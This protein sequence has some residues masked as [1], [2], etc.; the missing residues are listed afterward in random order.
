MLEGAFKHA[1]NKGNKG[2]IHAGGVQWMTAGRGVVHSET[3]ATE[4]VNRGLQLVRVMGF[5]WTVFCSS[6]SPP[7]P[8]P[9]VSFLMQ[10]SLFVV[11]VNSPC[12]VLVVVSLW[13]VGGRGG[14]V[15]LPYTP[16]VGESASQGQNGGGPLP[17]CGALRDAHV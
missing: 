15:P 10:S 9:R 13:C 2:T 14:G 3:P 11:V 7:L 5:Y 4:G 8:L 6:S 17:G 1:D 12:G 16:I